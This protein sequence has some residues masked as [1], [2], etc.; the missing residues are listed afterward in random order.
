MYFDFSTV[1]GE[2][3]LLA[4]LLF[5]V[6]AS[7]GGGQFH[8]LSSQRPS[9]PLGKA[10]EGERGFFFCSKHHMSPRHTLYRFGITAMTSAHLCG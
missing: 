2:R 7:S 6:V 9:L 8:A 4:G 5:V 10:G 1:G 3:W